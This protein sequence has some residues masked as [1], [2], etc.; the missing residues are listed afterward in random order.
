MQWVK[1]LIASLL[2]C[3]LMMFVVPRVFML[4]P[5]C[6]DTTTRLSAVCGP[7]YLAAFIN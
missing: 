4:I 3:A 7:R 5:I 6:I 1:K 2:L